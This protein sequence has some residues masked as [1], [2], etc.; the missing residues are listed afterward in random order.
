M[1]GESSAAVAG[2]GIEKDAQTEIK[3]LRGGVGKTIEERE[4]AWGGY[5]WV[6]GGILA[7]PQVKFQLLKDTGRGIKK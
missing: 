6:Q 4:R 1:G 7:S 5:K 3:S 2:G